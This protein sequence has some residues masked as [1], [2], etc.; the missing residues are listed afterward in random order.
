M[1]VEDYLKWD[2]KAQRWQSFL[3][4]LKEEIKFLETA[5]LTQ[6]SKEEMESKDGKARLI[7]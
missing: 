4:H 6:P 5:K 1:W 3:N 7:I 2:I